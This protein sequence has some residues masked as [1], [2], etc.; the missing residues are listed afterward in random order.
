MG[1]GPELSV[2]QK[3]FNYELSKEQM[4]VEHTVCRVK[5]HIRADEFRN[6]LRH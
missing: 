2:A 3:A 4:V 1:E 6:R 5:F